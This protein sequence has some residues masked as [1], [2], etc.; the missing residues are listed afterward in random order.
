MA[1][2]SDAD[3][4]ATVQQLR[5]MITTFDSLGCPI[6]TFMADKELADVVP[7]GLSAKIINVGRDIHHMLV[8]FEK[9]P[10]YKTAVKNMIEL[11]ERG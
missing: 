2:M 9:H 1:K 8:D 5:R 10:K 3:I 6:R 7:Q 11:K 4:I